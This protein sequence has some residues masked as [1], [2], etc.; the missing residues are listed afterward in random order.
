MSDLGEHYFTYS[1]YPHKNNWKKAKTLTR[2]LE[3]NN[4]MHAVQIAANG[5]DKAGS[6]MSLNAENVT[7]EAVKKCEDEDAFIVRMVEKTGAS[8]DVVC[9]LFAD[10]DKAFAC[11]LL[12]RGDVP[13]EAAGNTLAFRINPFEI[14]CFKVFLK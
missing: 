13:V 9:T 3:L 2:G 14:K 11:D 1:L 10:V 8:A 4:P 6:F 7:L 5:A 12:E